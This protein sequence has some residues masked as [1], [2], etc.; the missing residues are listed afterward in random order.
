MDGRAAANNKVC[1]EALMSTRAD[2]QGG[3][4]APSAPG[5]RAWREVALDWFALSHMSSKECPSVPFT[6]PTH[7]KNESCQH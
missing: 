3:Q 4:S 1:E 2:G 6:S 5:V 7:F